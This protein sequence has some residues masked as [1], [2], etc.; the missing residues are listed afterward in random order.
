MIILTQFACL[1]FIIVNT[2]MY[3]FPMLSIDL[4]INTSLIL[5]II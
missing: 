2:T 3:L 4:I 1:T 5:N